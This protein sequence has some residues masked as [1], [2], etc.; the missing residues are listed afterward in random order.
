M[1]YDG[2]L[3]PPYM[4]NWGINVNIPA[5]PGAGAQ[6]L[7][8][9]QV[10]YDPLGLYDIRRHCGALPHEPGVYEAHRSCFDAA[11]L[12]WIATSLGLASNSQPIPQNSFPPEFSVLRQGMQKNSSGTRAMMRSHHQKLIFDLVGVFFDVWNKLVLMYSSQTSLMDRAY[13]G[14]TLILHV[15]GANRPNS[16]LRPEF[17][18]ADVYF[19][20]YLI[21]EDMRF[22]S[23]ISHITQQFITEIGLP[24]IERWE[25]CARLK[26]TLTQGQGISRPLPYPEQDERP[27][28][29]PIGSST[30][31]IHGRK[32]VADATSTAD[33]GQAKIIDDDDEGYETFEPSLTELQVFDDLEKCA[34]M[35]SEVQSI[36]SELEVA[37]S[38]L[39]ETKK[40]LSDALARECAL[41]S[42]LD[43]AFVQLSARVQS[44]PQA[45]PS[46]PSPSSPSRTPTATFTS[47]PFGV[48]VPATPR[49]QIYSFNPASPANRQNYSPRSPRLETTSHALVADSSADY[50][51]FLALHGISHL[52]LFVEYIRKNVPISSWSEHLHQLDISSDIISTLI[53]L[54]LKASAL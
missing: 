42:R 32:V 26:W 23:F 12:A 11:D 4:H 40:A 27:T 16:L 25:R 41:T 13:G 28:A 45:P 37:Q 50:H 18:K 31:L 17:V 52:T 44:S 9:S 15:E 33:V 47:S 53:S 29:T 10:R 5:P 3:F 30:F 39:M 21:N 49:K 24:V 51:N 35:E 34:Y 22:S 2:C 1:D 46:S 54:L 48:A 38:E 7:A 8:L 20:G 19:P 14:V 6:P 43:A 36:R